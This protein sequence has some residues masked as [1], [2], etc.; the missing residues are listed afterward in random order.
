M[1]DVYVVEAAFTGPR[2]FPMDRVVEV[3][4]CRMHRDGT[5][6]DTVYNSFVF[7]DP[8]DLGKDSLDYLQE[9]YGI[10]AE[11][12]Y[13]APEVEIV[14]KELHEKLYD[15][16][17]TSFDVNRTFGQ[18]LCVEPWDLNGELSL[19][20]SISSR[21]P[22]EYSSTLQEAY[23]YVTPGNPMD[24]HG[25]TAMDRCLMSTSIMMRL[26]TTGFFRSGLPDGY[27]EPYQ[28]DKDR[29]DESQDVQ[30]KQADAQDRLQYSADEAGHQAEQQGVGRYEQ[31][32]SDY[33]EDVSLYVPVVVVDHPQ[34]EEAEESRYDRE[35]H[36]E[37]AA[38]LAGGGLVIVRFGPGRLLRN[39]G[40]AFGAG[41]AVVG[42]GLPA[43][44]AIASHSFLLITKPVHVDDAMSFPSSEYT[45]TS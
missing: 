6:F 9:N 18:F 16:E 45:R 23:D 31:D 26:R 24:V 43:L 25:S 34:A 4:V 35:E 21:L 19:F 27:V 22:P 38:L 13:V 32:E 8:M 42:D 11:V 44:G 10:T 12:L 39:L 17:A 37:A 7:A 28:G 3:A 15:T 33:E 30:Q 14:A 40:I 41:Y 20:P 2:G 29:D 36:H 1:D 5:D